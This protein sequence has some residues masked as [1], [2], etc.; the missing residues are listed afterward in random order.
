[1]LHLSSAGEIL[2]HVD[3]I[4]A[5]GCH[6]LGVSLGST[7]IMRMEDK[8]RQHEV[9]FDVLLPSGSVYVQRSVIGK[10]CLQSRRHTDDHD[11]VIVSDT[12]INTLS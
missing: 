10:V 4:E 7:R 2:P 12:I 8:D 1:M 3:N 5:S 6:I 9:G 11:L